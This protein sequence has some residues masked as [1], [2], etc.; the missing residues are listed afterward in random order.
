VAATALQRDYLQ[1]TNA[2]KKTLAKTSKP[3]K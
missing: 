3:N 2:A 1:K